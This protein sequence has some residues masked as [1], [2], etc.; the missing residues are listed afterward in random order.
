[1]NKDY[2]KQL[3]LGVYGR[4]WPKDP[5]ET[6]GDYRSGVITRPGAVHF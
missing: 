3:F 5:K 2:Q 1:V 4:P 6:R